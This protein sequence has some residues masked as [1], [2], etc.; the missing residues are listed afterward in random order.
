MTPSPNG[1]LNNGRFG[2]GNHG[3]PGNPFASQV[4]KLRSVLLETV[5]PEDMKAVVVKLVEL[6]KGG[7]LAAAKIIIDRT[8]GKSFVDRLPLPKTSTNGLPTHDAHGVPLTFEEKKEWL[9]ER[10]NRVIG[11][12]G[13]GTTTD[14][15][16]IELSVDERRSRVAEICRTALARQTE[17]HETEHEVDS[18]AD[19]VAT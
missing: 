2:I 19:E 14:K 16:A 7:D 17:Q 12:S 3:G 13:N 9:R 8:C 5:T 10:I 18:D 1:R 6:A 15:A 4:G 11:D